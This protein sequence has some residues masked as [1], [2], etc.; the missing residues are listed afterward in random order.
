[1]AWRQQKT[2][3]ANSTSDKSDNR[4]D[5]FFS[6]NSSEPRFTN[7][8]YDRSF[9]NETVSTESANEKKSY[10]EGFDP[11]RD[12]EMRSRRFQNRSNNFRSEGRSRYNNN[13]R[14]GNYNSDRRGNYNSDRRGHYN[15]DYKSNSC[16]SFQKYGNCRFGDS[17]KFG[18]DN[19][20]HTTAPQ[21]KTCG[22]QINSIQELLDSGKYISKS[23][24]EELEQ[25]ILDLKEKQK[26]EF[27][28]LK[29]I[30]GSSPA[31]VL[32]SSC[33]GN[34]ASSKVL[35]PEGIEEANKR[36]KDRKA[37]EEERKK[38][39]QKKVYDEHVESD[40]DGDDFFDDDDSLNDEDYY[41]EQEYSDR[42]L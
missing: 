40:Y 12:N 5:K 23:K 17:C 10:H 16:R 2:T 19:A 4:F 15:S 29:S 26:N 11:A 41:D 6:K 32:K 14:R 18:H 27:P 7:K 42:D 9:D 22:A 24:K 25:E 13:N 33:W 20:E 39:E 34:I 35:S 3:S 30:H 37:A 21:T 31:P 38:Q 28:E 36:A 8:K 1:M